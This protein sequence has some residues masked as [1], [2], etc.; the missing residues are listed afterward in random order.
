MAH[1]HLYMEQA[2]MGRAEEAPTEEGEEEDKRTVCQ[3][4]RRRDL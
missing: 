4:E 3:G 2:A 1:N